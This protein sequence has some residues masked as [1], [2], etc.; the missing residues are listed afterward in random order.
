MSVG[1]SEVTSESYRCSGTETCYQGAKTYLKK[2]NYMLLQTGQGQ[3]VAN[4]TGF[5]IR[6]ATKCSLLLLVC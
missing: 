3:A 6:E 5:F 1:L 2:A 4:S